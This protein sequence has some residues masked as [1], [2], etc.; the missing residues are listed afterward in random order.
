[1][2]KITSILMLFLMC[3]GMA[4]QAAL[5][6][7]PEFSTDGNI[8]WYKINAGYRGGCLTKV[9]NDIKHVDFEGLRSLWCFKQTANGVVMCN[10]A[11]GQLTHDLHF[12]ETG[13]GW[14]FIN[15]GFHHSNQEVKGLAISKTET[16]SDN[17]CLDAHNNNDIAVGVWK[18]DINDFEGTTW[19]FEAFKPLVSNVKEFG[20]DLVYT[21]E[22]PRGWMM[23]K[24]GCPNVV[25]TKKYPELTTGADV[26]ACQWVVYKSA[27]GNFY[28]YNLGAKKFLGITGENNKSIPFVADPVTNKLK[29][30]ASTN[31]DFKAEFP[32]MPY[33]DGVTALNHTN[34]FGDGLI[35]WTG[36]I[37]QTNDDGNIHK[38]NAVG[39][40]SAEDYQLISQKVTAFEEKYQLEELKNYYLA[41]AG[42]V[43]GLS[44]ADTKMLLTKNTLAEANEFIENCTKLVF[45]ADKLYRI[46]NYLRDLA[47]DNLSHPGAGAFMGDNDKA[48]A[49]VSC[50]SKSMADASYVWSFIKNGDNYMIKNLNSGKF[51]GKT[52]QNAS[53]Y[54]Q[55]TDSESEA[56]IYQLNSLGNGQY[57]FFCINGLGDHKA[58][59]ASSPNRT[60]AGV[61]NWNANPKNNSASA[62][63][64]VEATELEVDMNAAGEAT[65]TSLY[66]PFDVTLP[67]EGLEAFTGTLSGNTLSLTKVTEVPAN[68][69]VILKGNQSKYTLNIATAQALVG[70][71]AIKGSNVN[72]E[73][74]DQSQFYVLG[75][76]AENGVGL[77]H[78]NATTLKANKAYVETTVGAQ[79]LKFDFNG[80][81]T[82]VE[83]V[84]VETE[85]VKSIYYDLSGR[86]VATPAH[87][88]CIKDG[89]KVY[90]K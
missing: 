50:H 43:D 28:M 17:S 71:N 82:G 75:N 44:V 19:S 32:L 56:G 83:G 58:L 3:F 16:I 20:N 86:R 54:L 13:N 22:S 26:P 77:Y 18:S 9:G 64:L 49:N 42:C 38:F 34:I 8:K 68:N 36:G 39:A 85:N 14:Y 61:M 55:Q 73:I 57:E 12:A 78:P 4:V 62:W 89:K 6:D 51:I 2:K 40:L 52:A 79:V 47:I 65:W 74:T 72:K 70:E 41:I 87:G 63:Y 30:K 88:L 23:Y 90:V 33:Y 53:T 80:E 76:T 81:T 67:A 29:F 46:K 11:G 15:H 35:A 48:G 27:R 66:L 21:V 7:M 45:N 84:E 5:T 37:N 31:A 10:A 60:G 69:G 24:E 1:M 59:H 25:S